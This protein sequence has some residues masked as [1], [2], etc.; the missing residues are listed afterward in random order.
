MTDEPVRTVRCAAVQLDPVLGDVDANVAACEAAVTAAAADGAEI[1]VLP[2]FFTTGVAFRADIAA[3]AQPEDG[4]VTA[5]LCDW[6][7]RH[8]VLLAGSLLVRDPDGEVRNAQLLIGPEGLLGRHDK[9][10][11]T[12]WENALYTGGADD[13]RFSVPGTPTSRLAGPLELGGALC[14]ELTRSQTVRRLAGRVDLV[15]AG[16]GWWSVPGWQP[17]PLFD[18]WERANGERARRAP[19]IFARFAGAPVVHAAHVG[20]VECALPGL[21]GR[22]RG[23]Y[24]GGTGVWDSAGEQIALLPP[25]S[26]GK[27]V[28][29]QVTG[30]VSMIRRRPDPVPPGYWLIPRGPVPTFAWHWQRWWGRR[31]YN[32]HV[33]R[34]VP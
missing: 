33:R 19:A 26:A 21:P 24:E 27:G 31:F 16:S 13:G 11:P 2:E 17:A 28:A 1:V 18:R 5:A 10:L 34:H 25:I 9:D 4:R 32:A 8:D 7:L 6:A 14:W 22:Y 3:G 15:L 20:G 30:E 12:M 23:H 29:Q